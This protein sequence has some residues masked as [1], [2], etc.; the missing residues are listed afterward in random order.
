MEKIIIMIINCLR[1][2]LSLLRPQILIN[3]IIEK[4]SNL[5]TFL[6][7]L[8]NSIWLDLQKVNY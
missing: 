3:L 2:Y 8:S 1:N 7:Y 5:I 4:S 6:L